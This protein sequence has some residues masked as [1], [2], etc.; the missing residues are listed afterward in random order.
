VRA[1][2]QQRPGAG[3]ERRIDAGQVER[4]LAGQRHRHDPAPV[5]DGH[6][7]ERV[8]HGRA[9]DDAVAGGREVPQRL[10]DA[11]HHVGHRPAPAHVDRPAPPAGREA[12]ERR[13]EPVGVRV[14]GV[15]VVQRCAQHPGDGRR[16]RHVEL[17]HPQRQHVRLDLAPLRAAPSAQV[18]ERQRVEVG[19]A[20][21][22]S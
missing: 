12:G 20:Q 7:E 2:Q 14:A 17:G 21:T 13:R 10:V 11:D 16:Q 9:H 3:A 1:R 6:R 15:A 22:P 8:V 18:G 5:L 19:H 4:A